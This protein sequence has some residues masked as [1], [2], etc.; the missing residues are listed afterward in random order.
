MPEP[1]KNR[2]TLIL[3]DISGYTRFLSAVGTAHQAQLEQGDTPAAY[4]LMTTLLDTIVQDLVPPFVLS[5]LVTRCSASPTM[6][7]WRYAATP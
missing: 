4:P 6:A 1:G 7:R 3:A 2:A 5:K